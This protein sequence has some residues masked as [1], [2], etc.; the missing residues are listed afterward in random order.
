MMEGEILVTVQKI[1]KGSIPK[2]APNAIR[3]NPDAFRVSESALEYFRINV[4]KARAK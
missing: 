1:K 2:T 3:F 4:I